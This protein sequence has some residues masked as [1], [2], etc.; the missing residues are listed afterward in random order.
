MLRL[1]KE[2]SNLWEG[3]RCYANFTILLI[4]SIKTNGDLIY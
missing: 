3:I 1:A 2:I 4:K